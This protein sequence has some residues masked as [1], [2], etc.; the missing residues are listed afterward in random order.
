[1]GQRG[2][3]RIYQRDGIWQLYW[4]Q[5]G[6]T[7]RRSLLTSDRRE[8]E[9]IRIAKAAELATG[10]RILATAPL[11][12]EWVARYLDW[13]S[14]THPADHSAR[15]G[16]KPWSLRFGARQMDSITTGELQAFAAE[17]LASRAPETVGREVR[18]IKAMYKRGVKWGELP[19]NP[20]ADLEAPRGVRSVAVEYYTAADLQRLYAASDAHRWIWQFLANTGLR[21][22]EALRARR[23]HI[24]QHAMIG[25]GTPAESVLR[26]ESTDAARTKSGRWR[27][28]PLNASA[29]AA[30]EHLG[31]DLLIPGMRPDSL[32]QAFER[33]ATRAGI[34]GNLHRLR[35][36]FCSHLVA[37]GVP[38]RTVQ[39]LAGHSSITVTER[40]AHLSPQTKLEAVQRVAL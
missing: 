38:L 2:Q 30:L 18:A 8:A 21:R 23:S 40:Y 25:T 27:E 3:P 11:W 29:I 32:T 5:D 10:A 22:S 35:H 20:A 14:T 6:R 37:A 34:G 17:R 26:I 12:R 33:C 16:L 19:S 1:M 24:H 9:R 36:T 15:S 31:P 13:F 4:R 39:V 7:F 28:L